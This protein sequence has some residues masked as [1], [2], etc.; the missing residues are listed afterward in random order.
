MFFHKLDHANK[1][2]EAAKKVGLEII[3]VRA[4]S[5]V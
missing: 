2:L 5:I 3:N 4:E 1:G